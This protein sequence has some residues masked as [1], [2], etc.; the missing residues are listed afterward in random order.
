MI[1]YFSGTGNS[2]A[3]ARIIANATGED[4]FDL[5]D[6]YKRGAF[7]VEIEQGSNLGIVFPVYRW[8]TPRIVDEFFRKA[9]FVTPDGSPFRPTYAYAVDIYGYFPG[10]EVSYLNDL[11][12]KEQ[13]F[14]LDASFEIPSVANCIYVSNPPSPE[15]QGKQNKREEEVAHAVAQRIVAQERVMEATGRVLGR[16]LSKATG[17]EEKPRSVKA[18]S[19]DRS[20]CISCGICARVCPT[21]TIKLQDGH[22]VW[23]GDDCTECLACIHR[24]PTEAIQY[25]FISK[26]RR[27]YQNPILKQAISQ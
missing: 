24:C 25:G 7:R 14:G 18:F 5:G 21:N 4:L 6:A 15:R 23:S 8:S 27:R 22:P 16:L 20:K 1:I 2:L 9:K 3:A 13:G 10:A 19:V 26:G 11:L 12:Q 17:T